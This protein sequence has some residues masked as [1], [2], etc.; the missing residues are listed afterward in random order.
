ML[1]PVH[2]QNGFVP[3]HALGHITYERLPITG[4][5]EPTT[6]TL[7]IRAFQIALSWGGVGRGMGEVGMPP[8]EQANHIFYWKGEFFFTGR[9]E[10]EQE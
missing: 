9:W 1:H 6:T 4:T 7:Y 5:N 10:P 2:Y 3:T 8:L